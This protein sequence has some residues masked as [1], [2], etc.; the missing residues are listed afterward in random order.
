ME[1]PRP[2]KKYEVI[3][4]RRKFKIIVNGK[5]Y[6]VEIEELKENKKDAPFTEPPRAEKGNAKKS[7]M[8]VN[9]DNLVTAPMPGKILKIVAKNGDSVNRGDVIMVLE[10]MKMENEI[11][12]PK[13]GIIEEIKVQPGDNVDRGEIL[14]VL[15]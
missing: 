14:A 13:D 15:R 5:E 11:T 6:V 9:S 8:K 10:A 3:D 4:M 1:A 7:A 2:T 12:A